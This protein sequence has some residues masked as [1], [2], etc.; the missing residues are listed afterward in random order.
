MRICGACEFLHPLCIEGF[1]IDGLL[2][3]Q[4]QQTGRDT[5]E[6]L[7][8][9]SETASEDAIRKEMLEQMKTILADKNLSY[10]QFYIK[11]VDEILPD[12]HTGKK[13]LIVKADAKEKERLAV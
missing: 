12:P 4:F 8:E 2:D 7:A 5:F 13:R 6:M 1:C 3:Y 11:F 10:V 9:I